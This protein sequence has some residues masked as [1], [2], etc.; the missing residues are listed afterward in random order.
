MKYPNLRF[1]FDRRNTASKEKKAPV[2]LEVALCSKR[3]D[4]PTGVKLYQDECD[5]KKKVI[6][7][8]DAYSLNV[9]LDEVMNEVR[10]FIISLQEANESFSFE[11]FDVYMK[12]TENEGSFL[13]FMFD[14]IKSRKEAYEKD[15]IKK[16]HTTNSMFKKGRASNGS[17]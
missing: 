5:N 10:K 13:D 15:Y 11:K 2:Y 6:N 16:I 3:R 8:S 12:G 14:Q 7:R 9:Q 4:V 1:V 17:F